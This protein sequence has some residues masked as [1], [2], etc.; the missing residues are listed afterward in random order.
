MRMASLRQ[1]LP[2]GF[3]RWSRRLQLENDVLPSPMNA[4]DSFALKCVGDL[5][6]RRFQWLLPR[7]DPHRFNRVAGNAT[8]ETTRDSFDFRKLWHYPQISVGR[9]PRRPRPY[10]AG[11][12]PQ[13]WRRFKRQDAKKSIKPPTAPCRLPAEPGIRYSDSY[14]P[15]ASLVA[16]FQVLCAEQ[17]VCK[18]EQLVCATPGEF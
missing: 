4:S 8:L 14:T 18:A 3:V 2:F 7:A 16:T 10:Y 6:S 1:L 15:N 5:R 12:V 11:R 9:S 17:S 13:P